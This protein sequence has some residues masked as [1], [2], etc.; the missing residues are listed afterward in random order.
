MSSRGP[1]HPA[2]TRRRPH[3]N[4][5]RR[6]R[7]TPHD[8]HRNLLDSRGGELGHAHFPNSRA[9]HAAGLAWA[10]EFGPAEFGPAEFGPADRWS[11]EGA[12]GL[13]R[14][15]AEFLVEAGCDVRDVPPHKISARGHGRHEGKTDR[16]DSQR[17]AAETQTNLRLARAFKKAVSAAPD[18]V[19]ERIAL[20]HN[21]RRSLTMIRVQLLGELD[22]LVHDLPE[23]LRSQLRPRQTVRARVNA[24]S[25]LNTS[26]VTDPT[27]ALR[28]RLIELRVAMLRDVLEQD[29]AATAELT[30][31]VNETHSTLTTLVGIAPRAAAAIIVEVGDI[32]RFSE[33]GFARFNGTA[34][35]PA[36][37]G[38]GGNAPLRHRLSRGSNRRL[39]AAIYRI[40]MIQLRYEPRARQIHDQ[41]RAHGHTRREAM[42]V[43]KRHLSNAIYR[44]MLRD[45]RR[46]ADL[47]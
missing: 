9:G 37:S 18:S 3:G 15:L 41:A 14:Q 5:H 17:V 4:Q 2:K 32:R 33:A 20:W 45:A 27:V 28:L 47:T 13:G 30:R 42:R 22:A 25:R 26:G 7:P 46:A 31:L 44:T 12:S 19:R 11:I 35:I 16:L 1:S 29:K 43:L 24:L 40:A 36:S 10:A 23:E 38:E 21:A 8:L 39:N 34:P 6:R